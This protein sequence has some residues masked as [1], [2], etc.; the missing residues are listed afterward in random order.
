MKCPTCGQEIPD[1]QSIYWQRN[2]RYKGLKIGKSKTSLQNYGCYLMCWSYVTKKDPLEV[3]KLFTDNGVYVYS[4][5]SKDYDI[6]DSAK[7]CKVLGLE[8]VGRFYNIGY[9]PKQELSIKEVYLGK[10]QHFV[11]RIIRD[12]KRLIFD[13]WEGCELDI[14]HYKFKSYRVFN[15]K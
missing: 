3:N 1:K 12:G 8:W 2:P 9:M 11:V 10:S 5:E 14:N 4:K 13:P 7:A 15:F 6:I